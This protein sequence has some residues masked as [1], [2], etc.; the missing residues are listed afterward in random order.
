M[1]TYTEDFLKEFR[2][3]FKKVYL[4]Y[5]IDYGRWNYKQGPWLEGVFELPSGWYIW[6]KENMY[7]TEEKQFTQKF[8]DEV[9]ND[10]I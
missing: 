7:I 3:Y 5:G 2:A 10:T 6:L 8:I 9:I 1:M 4:V